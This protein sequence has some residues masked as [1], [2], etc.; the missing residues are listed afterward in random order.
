MPL[1]RETGQSDDIGLLAFYVTPGVLN[2]IK[3]GSVLGT[4]IEPSVM[5]TRMCVDQAV[6]ALEGKKD[7]DAAPML[8]MVDT[9]SIKDLGP[10]ERAGAGGLEADLP[11]RLS[12]GAGPGRA[13]LARLRW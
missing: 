7:V 12:A 2:G 10:V 11:R 3:R 1:L 4:V 6:Q 8:D 9:T 5:F 13:G